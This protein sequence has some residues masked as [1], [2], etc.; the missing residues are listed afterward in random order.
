MFEDLERF[1]AAHRPC[2]ELTRDV[3]ELAA[4][5]YAVQVTCACGATFERWVTSEI[6]DR[7]LHS[8]LLAFPT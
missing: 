7:D 1:V 2:G 8:R 4:T 3:S 5:G 6:A